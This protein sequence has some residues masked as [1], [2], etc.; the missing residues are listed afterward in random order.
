MTLSLRF[1]LL[2]A[3]AVVALLPCMG[4]A[5]TPGPASIRPDLTVS[6]KDEPA[7]ER[8]SCG[9]PCIPAPE[10][11]IAW[12]P[13]DEDAGAASHNELIHDND[14]IPTGNVT[15]GPG[16]VG[17]AAKFDPG[18]SAVEASHIDPLDFNIDE[19][20]S[21]VTWLYVPAGTDFVP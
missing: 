14:G 6:S 9:I 3:S 19:D 7:S 13:F 8:S 17:N 20:F 12:W 4:M 5:P 10:G 15:S 16:F 2:Q 1:H 18:F 11:L 21:L